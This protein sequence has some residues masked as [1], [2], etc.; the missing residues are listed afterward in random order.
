M[1]QPPPHTTG[2]RSNRWMPLRLACSGDSS[3]RVPI[4]GLDL[5]PADGQRLWW[6][7]SANAQ[8]RSRKNQPPI[9]MLVNALVDWV[10]Q[11]CTKIVANNATRVGFGSRNNPRPSGSSQAMAAAQNSA[12]PT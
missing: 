7:D 5:R 12:N 3:V 11:S 2:P 4:N 8:P 9:G 10:G 1:D 6:R